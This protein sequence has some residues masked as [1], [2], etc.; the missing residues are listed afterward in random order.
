MKDRTNENQ[1]LRDLVK[2][3]IRN[4]VGLMCFMHNR[5]YSYPNSKYK[6][7]AKSVLS[8]SIEELKEQFDILMH[9]GDQPIAF[10]QDLLEELDLDIKSIK[11]D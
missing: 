4:H 7:F 5:S 10:Y 1:I 11:E 9:E 6:T 3:L 8:E 2:A